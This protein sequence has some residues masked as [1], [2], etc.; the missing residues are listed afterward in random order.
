MRMDVKDDCASGAEAVERGRA[1]HRRRQELM[2][3][4]RQ[5]V[6]PASPSAPVIAP[7]LVVA[8]PTPPSRVFLDPAWHEMPMDGYEWAFHAPA[9][10]VPD[11][12]PTSCHVRRV[13]ARYFGISET[14]LIA[15]GRRNA[16]W[17]Q[18][19]MYVCRRCTVDST[20]KIGRRFGDR[21]HSTAMHA[22]NVIN[23]LVVSQDAETLRHIAAIEAYVNGAAEP[24]DVYTPSPPP[25]PE[26]PEREQIE[27][28]LRAIVDHSGLPK[29][30]II[31]RE[32][33]DANRWR[34]IA[35]YLARTDARLPLRHISRALGYHETSITRAGRY[36]LHRIEAGDQRAI[37]DVEAI[38][39]RLKT[40]SSWPPAPR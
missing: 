6:P 11:K 32:Q 23:D 9:R 5:F 16:R 24:M 27:R 17:R 19:A 36:I 35:V 2:R 39:L 8:L 20:T 14:V 25:A 26:R 22:V 34:W 7:P 29:H 12:M 4:V 31:C 28:I 40:Q 1:A 30:T 21:D 3:P 13:A 10:I 33:K 15:E 38:R 18:I 37:K